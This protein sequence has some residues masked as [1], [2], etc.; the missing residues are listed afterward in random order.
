MSEY[1]RQMREIGV[2]YRR[3]FGVHYP[4]MALVGVTELFDAAAKV[5]IVATAVIPERSP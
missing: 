2:S 1:K 4:A 3:H 5:E